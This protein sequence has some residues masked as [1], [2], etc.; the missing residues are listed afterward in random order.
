MIELLAALA[1]GLVSS[2]HC[3]ALS[4]DTQMTCQGI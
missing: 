2:G 1:P 3:A 4:T